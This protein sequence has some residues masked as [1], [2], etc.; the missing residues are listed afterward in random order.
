MQIFICM[1]FLKQYF[2]ISAIFFKLLFQNFTVKQESR[3]FLIFVVKNNLIN[4]K[5]CLK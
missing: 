5:F 1:T 3:N 4:K 2:E